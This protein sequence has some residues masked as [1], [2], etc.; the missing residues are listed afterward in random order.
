[1]TMRMSGASPATRSISRL[2]RRVSPGSRRRAGAPGSS[3][4]EPATRNPAASSAATLEAAVPAPPE[5]IAPAWPIRLPSGAVRPA[6]KATFGMSARCSAAHAAAVLLGRAADL[7]DQHDRLGVGVVR[8]QL[9]DVEERRP[10]DRVAADPDAGRLA[11]AGVGHRLDR[12]V[13]QRPG[14]AD[15][16]DPAL[17][18]D[19]ARD[20]PDLGRARATWRPG[21]SG[22]SAARRPAGPPRPP[23]T[24]SSAGMPSVMQKIVRDPGRGRLHDRVRRAGRRDEDA[25]RV[26]AGLADRLGRPCRTRRRCRRAR[27]WPP[28]PGVTPATIAVP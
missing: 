23:A 16:A 25:G 3:V 26:G 10:D 4:G 19:R 2:M 21:S 11:D 5:M 20:D 14:A 6:M 27:V 12:L 28:L 17:A 8:E 9:Q 18:V 7:A 1:M 22:R 15:D 13:G 24:M